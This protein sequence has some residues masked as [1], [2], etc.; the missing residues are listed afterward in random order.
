MTYIRI[1]L[2]LSLTGYYSIAAQVLIIREFLITFSGNELSIG[3][4]LSNWLLLEALGS[5]YG[6]HFSKKIRLPVLTFTTIQF[7]L[8]LFLPVIIYSTRI[9]KVYLTTGIGEAIPIPL[10]IIVSVVLLLPV[11][12]LNGTQFSLGCRLLSTHRGEQSD[13]IGTVYIYEA[14]GSLVGGVFVT[15]ICLTYLNTFQSVFLLSILNSISALLLLKKSKEKNVYLIRYFRVLHF[16]LLFILIFI[17]FT[18]NSTTIHNKSSAVQWPGYEVIANK[19]SIYGNSI[20]LEREGQYELLSNGV[21]LFSYPISNISDVETIAHIP[22][23]FHP[24]PESVLLMGGGLNGILKEMIKHPL[25]KVDYAELDPVLTDIILQN[26]GGSG[27]DYLSDHRIHLHQTDGRQFLVS[28]NFQYDVII[29]NLPDPSTLE[30]NRF[31]TSEFFTL[32]KK[33]LTPS[34]VLFLNLPGGASYINTYLMQLSAS[35]LASIESVFKFSRIFP[36]ESIMILASDDIHF[37]EINQDTLSRRLK[38]RMINTRAISEGFLYHLFDPLRT[39]WFM[40]ERQRIISPNQ[41]LDFKPVAVYYDLLYW[42]TRLSPGFSRIYAWFEKISFSHIVFGVTFIFLVI[43]LLPSNRF[44]KQKTAT[45]M[46]I[47][48]SGF[49]AMGLTLIMILSFQ[50]IF[51]YVY[52]WI[53]MIISSFMLG[54]AIGGIISIRMWVQRKNS[55]RILLMTELGLLVYLFLVLLVFFQLHQTTA[56]MIIYNILPVL[57]LIITGLGGVVIGSQFPLAGQI[58]K[59]KDANLIKA[60]GTIYSLDLLGAWSAGIIVSL[61]LVPILGMTDTLLVFLIINIGSTMVLYMS[62]KIQKKRNEI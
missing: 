32:C 42:N 7:F 59:E 37:S 41:N 58:F 54:M 36:F 49:T 2:A 23:A 16:L 1:L 17:V 51:G 28:N 25:H 24:N 35:V 21:P 50:A 10:L 11:A 20:L 22:I 30:I 4:F 26:I 57:I 46:V 27:F 53:G 61:F 8:A 12:V 40:E 34:G 62:N 48:T 14:L 15:Y 52:F 60:A 43:V 18:G 47:I 9:F 13:T 44:N 3:I 19:N 5:Y 55:Q 31:Y 56:S 33:H 39:R 6:G 45:G 38:D 29:L